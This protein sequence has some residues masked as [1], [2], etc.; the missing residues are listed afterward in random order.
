MILVVLTLFTLGCVP[1]I[2]S[3]RG[4]WRGNKILWMPNAGVGKLFRQQ[5]GRER[6]GVALVVSAYVL[7][8]AGW[9][10]VLSTRESETWATVLAAA[11]SVVWIA[12]AASVASVHR[13]GRPEFLVPPDRRV[14]R[15]S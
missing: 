7:C 1:S 12:S 6:A 3:M 2:P 4:A 10:L 8:A 11:S 5:T 15:R 9:L 13:L 14:S